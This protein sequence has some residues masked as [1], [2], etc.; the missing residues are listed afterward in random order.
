MLI[1]IS[2]I[3]HSDAILEDTSTTVVG[4]G[5][6]CCGFKYIG[7]CD[8]CY[9]SAH[10]LTLFSLLY[11]KLLIG[12]EFVTPRLLTRFQFNFSFDKYS[13]QTDMTL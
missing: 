10:Q 12:F 6:K 5:L 8:N 7:N 4:L 13:V 9:G 11:K 3:L 1:D 2:Y